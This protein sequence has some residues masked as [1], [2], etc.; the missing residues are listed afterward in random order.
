MNSSYI[1]MDTAAL[2]SDVLEFYES[3]GTREERI[4]ANYMQGSV[5][6]D[7]SDSPMALEYYMKAVSLA[8][9]T[10]NNCDYELLSRIYAQMAELFHKQRYPQKEL[11]M[12]NTARTMA[13]KANDTI[14]YL[15]CTDRTAGTYWMAGSKDK[16]VEIAKETY[17]AYKKIG[18]DSLAASD[19]AAT[20]AYNLEHNALGEAK[21]EI[22]EYVSKSGLV[23]EKGNVK[24]RCEMFYGTLGTYYYK[25][26][27]NDFA[28]H[29]YRKL[30]TF[31][32]KKLNLENGYKGLMNVYC[33]LNR[34]DSVVKYAELYAN[35]NDSANILNSANEVSRVQALYDYSEHQRNSLAKAKENSLL[36]RAF[37]LTFVL[38]I[39]CSVGIYMYIRKRAESSRNKI[40][41]ANVKYVMLLAEHDKV[42]SEYNRYKADKSAFENEMREKINKLQ[43]ALSTYNNDSDIGKLSLEQQ[44]H[45]HPIADTF[46]SYAAKGD[47]PTEK[48]WEI[49]QDVVEKMMPDFFEAMEKRSY[50]PSL[51]ELRFC[52]LT[53]LGFDPSEIF[54]LMEITKQRASNMRSRLNEKLFHQSGS[55]TFRKNIYRL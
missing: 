13:K 3:H 2:V 4:R 27:M 22:D 51:Q 55:A 18:A 24:E 12:W 48:D 31:D 42:V 9:T 43:V 11:E 19:L 44:L 29:F 33:K 6:R 54:L 40:N 28:L 36:W 5:Y 10:S 14:M 49:L 41:D 34:P 35:A 17:K 25:V 8:D 16:A 45:H 53:R 50:K 52:L 37:F 7:R 21:S 39:I 15:Q 32:K 46:H 47:T 26:G 23:D 1:P 20:I 38:V 30:I